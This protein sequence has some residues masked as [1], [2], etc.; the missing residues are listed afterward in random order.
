MDFFGG[1]EGGTKIVISQWIW[2]VGCCRARGLGGSFLVN[3]EECVGKK[4]IVESNLT[5]NF[6]F[7]LWGKGGC[8][9]GF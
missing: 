3:I 7:C 9:G 4:G 1:G 5:I 2:G 6:N 8:G